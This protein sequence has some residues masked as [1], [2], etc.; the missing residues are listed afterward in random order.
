[1]GAIGM[2]GIWESM[3]SDTDGIIRVLLIETCE[4]RDVPAMRKCVAA[5][6][7]DAGAIEW[8]KDRYAD[9]D[10]DIQELLPRT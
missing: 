2:D 1:M 8:C 10:T 6:L 5:A 3:I 4:D 9:G 7:G